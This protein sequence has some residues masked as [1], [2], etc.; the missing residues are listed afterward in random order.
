[1]RL[2]AVLDAPIEHVLALAAEYDL[3]KMWNSFMKAS[4]ILYAE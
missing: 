1:M 4:G 2:E 3:T